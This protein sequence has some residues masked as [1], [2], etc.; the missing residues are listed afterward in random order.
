MTD[1]K[2]YFYIV[3]PPGA[4]KRAFEKYV[5]DGLEFHREKRIDGE[6]FNFEHE[7]DVYRIDVEFDAL[8]A[9]FKQTKKLEYEYNMYFTQQLPQRIGD[10]N[11]SLLMWKYAQFYKTIDRDAL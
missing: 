11:V 10:E 6:C 3:C 1:I 7:I 2:Y 5:L 4:N 9:L 8:R